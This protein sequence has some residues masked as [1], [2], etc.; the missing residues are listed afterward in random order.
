MA[1]I[2]KTINQPDEVINAFAD[3]LGYQEVLPNPAYSESIVDGQIVGNGEPQTIPNPINR[4]EFV[5]ERFDEV[6]SAWFSQ[7]AERDARLASEGTIKQTVDATK[8]AIKSTISTNI[9]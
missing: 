1:T 3:D 6:A 2:T 4:T 9:T 5:S 8:A 7:F